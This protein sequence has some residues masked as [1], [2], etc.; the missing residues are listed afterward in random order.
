MPLTNTLR[1]R[2]HPALPT[3]SAA[4]FVRFAR[5]L[6]HEDPL[7]PIGVAWNARIIDVIDRVRRGQML[8]DEAGLEGVIL[9]IGDGH[10]ALRAGDSSVPRCGLS[11]LRFFGQL[12]EAVKETEAVRLPPATAIALLMEYQPM[13]FLFDWA[14]PTRVTTTSTG[15]IQ[16]G[17]RASFSVPDVMREEWNE[18]YFLWHVE[19]LHV[20]ERS[21]AGFSWDGTPF[22]AAPSTR[23]RPRT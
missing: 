8:E 22:G 5:V 3:L 21:R 11:L 7:I 12:S 15:R 23:V 6:R 4:A 19:H 20:Q 2:T 10:A 17:G 16:L 1:A 13:P 9:A 14:S 18:R